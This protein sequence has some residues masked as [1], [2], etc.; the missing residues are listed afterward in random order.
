[1]W[2]VQVHPCLV[3]SQNI[4]LILIDLNPWQP[5]QSQRKGWGKAY[6]ILVP[7]YTNTLN[8]NGS[9]NGS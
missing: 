2:S 5:F 4:K 7:I 1:M 3:P 6:Q 9:I 8:I